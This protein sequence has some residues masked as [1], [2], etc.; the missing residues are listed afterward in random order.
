MQLRSKNIR[1][2][3]LKR[4]WTQQHFADV[5]GLSLRTIQRIEKTGN[6]APETVMCLCAVLEVELDELREVPQASLGQL[7]EVS[8]WGN[9]IVI[10]LAIFA[11]ILVGA[12]GTYIFLN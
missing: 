1:D 6:A 2:H 8:I 5:C 7:K 11:G 3:R 12:V 4:K 9:L 10:C